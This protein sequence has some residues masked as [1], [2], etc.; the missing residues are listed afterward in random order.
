MAIN[1]L[2]LLIFAKIFL[3]YACLQMFQ[4]SAGSVVDEHGQ[5]EYV[6]APSAADAHRGVGVHLTAAHDV[7]VGGVL[8][9]RMRDA[10]DRRHEP[11]EGG[12]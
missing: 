10:I 4:D 9:E 5:C 2:P 1:R 6:T 11:P 8:L 12:R 7:L 3:R